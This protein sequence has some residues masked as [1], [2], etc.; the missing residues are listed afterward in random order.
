MHS[1]LI[2]ITK[3]L[4]ENEYNASME[5][6]STTDVV[7]RYSMAN[8]FVN[9]SIDQMN[10]LFPEIKWTKYF[11][12]AFGEANV[13]VDHALIHSKEYFAMLIVLINSTSTRTLNNYF[14]WSIVAK[15]LPYLGPQF[16]HMSSEF[17]QKILVTDVDVNDNGSNGFKFYQTQWQQCVYVACDGL[18]IPSI[19]LYLQNKKDYLQ[20]NAKNIG[21]LIEMMKTAFVGIIEKQTW[22]ESD[23]IKNILLKRV[24][25]ISSN[26]GLPSFIYNTSIVHSMYS[27]LNIDEQRELIDNI[28]LINKHESVLSVQKL[29]QATN[30][31]QEWLFNLLEVNA[32]YDSGVNNISMQ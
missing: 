23:Q 9:V 12:H 21:Q 2:Q 17:Q 16:K 30:P 14:G 24:K 22:I 7:D 6:N 19:M 5:T 11:E 15:Y 32:F 4:S 8:M 26:V 13:T 25:E 18:K 27:D 31:D 3:E 20:Q 10:E 1:I 28:F 29:N